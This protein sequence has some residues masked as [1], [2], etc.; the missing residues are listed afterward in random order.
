M[1]RPTLRIPAVVLLL[2]VAPYRF[3]AYI[4]NAFAYSDWNGLTGYADL[5]RTAQYRAGFSL[6]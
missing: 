6:G 1:I 5:A 3:V 2:L 4:G